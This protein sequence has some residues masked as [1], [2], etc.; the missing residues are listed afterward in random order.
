MGNTL[1][2]PATL[3]VLAFNMAAAR[4]STA[5]SSQALVVSDDSQNDQITHIYEYHSSKIDHVAILF[6]RQRG[7]RR[8]VE[9]MSKGCTFTDE[10]GYWN[11]GDNEER[12]DVHF[13][14]QYQHFRPQCPLHP[15]VVYRFDVCFDGK[16][17]SWLGED[18][19]IAEIKLVHIRS[20]ITVGRRNLL[21]EE[22]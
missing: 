18:D 2:P 5:L 16:R 7:G 17:A 15:T 13:N 4:S 14:Y 1:H 19:K 8:S 9:F 10:H 11:L 3:A 6:L 21:T 20:F 12:L 22:L